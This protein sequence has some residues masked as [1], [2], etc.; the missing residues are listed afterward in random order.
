[1]LRSYRKADYER[2][3]EIVEDIWRFKEAFSP[4]ALA[5]LFLDVYVEGSLAQSNFAVVVEQQ[6][7]V[8]GFLFGSHGN[9]RAFMAR[10]RASLRWFSLLVRWASF[11]R[12]FL[13]SIQKEA[14]GA[15]CMR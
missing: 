14:T 13:R 12:P 3:K 9:R 15:S 11:T 10:L 2:C 6:A 1:M 8:C 4:H 7:N 5:E